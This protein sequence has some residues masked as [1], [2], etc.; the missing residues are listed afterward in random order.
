MCSYTKFLFISKKT[1]LFGTIY[2]SSKRRKRNKSI[3][4]AYNKYGTLFSLSNHKLIVF[5]IVVV[6]HLHG[7]L[8]KKKK[9]QIF[10]ITI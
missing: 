9:K 7:K 1:R 4:T 10:F 8:T 3:Y 6:P 5:F 2:T